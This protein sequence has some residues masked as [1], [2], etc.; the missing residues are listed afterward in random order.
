MDADVEEISLDQEVRRLVY[1][2]VIREGLPPTVAETAAALSRP[3][4]EVNLCFRRLADAHILVLQKGSG[5][6]LMAAPFSAVPT[7]FLVKVGDRKYYGN[8]IWDALGIPSMLKQDGI[9]NASC[10]CCGTA[11]T[12]EVANG[13][14]AQARGLA[15]FA[16]A[17]AR[18]WDDVVFS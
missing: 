16:V 14:L 15:H 4:D 13:S 11:M 18:W 7:A 2:H 8:C 10:G 9:V 12:L 17:A 1:D 5:E 3:F 6:I